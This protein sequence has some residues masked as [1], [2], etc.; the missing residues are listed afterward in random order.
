V[1]HV[2]RKIDRQIEHVSKDTMYQEIGPV[3]QFAPAYGVYPT[4]TTKY[5]FSIDVKGNLMIRSQVTTH[6]LHKPPIIGEWITEVDIRDNTPIPFEIMNLMDDL[7]EQNEVY[8]ISHW[9]FVIGILT[10]MK[11]HS[12][13]LYQDVYSKNERLAEEIRVLTAQKEQLERRLHT[14]ERR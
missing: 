11:I 2:V 10:S 1:K 7:F 9:K 6:P 5:T 4:T 13:E 14:Y 8:F 12:S 3:R